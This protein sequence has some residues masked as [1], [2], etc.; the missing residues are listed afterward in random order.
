[1][2]MGAVCGW[3][4]SIALGNS[5]G[6]KYILGGCFAGVILI[7][8]CRFAAALAWASLKI[9]LSLAACYLALRLIVSLFS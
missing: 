8:V 9:A 1:M 5:G 3:L 2:V 6:I 4:Y 7:P